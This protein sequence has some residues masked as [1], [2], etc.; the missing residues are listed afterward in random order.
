MK[1]V[2]LLKDILINVKGILLKDILINVKGLVAYFIINYFDAR[3]S[4]RLGTRK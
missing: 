4:Y 3:P 1:K 2:I